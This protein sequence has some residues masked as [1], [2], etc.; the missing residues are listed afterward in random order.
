MQD[1]ELYATILG[2]HPPWRVERVDARSKEGEV[3]VFLE[4]DGSA[5]C[6]PT[7]QVASPRYDARRRSWRHLDTCQYRTVLTADVPRVSCKEHGIHQ[8]SVPWAEPGGRFTALFERLAIDWLTEA[9]ITAVARRLR[10]SWDELD[11][12]MHRAGT[13]LGRRAHQQLAQQLPRST[14]P[15]GDAR[16]ALPLVRLLRL[17]AHRA[18]GRETAERS[19]VLI[20]RS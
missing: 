5:L 2:I 1:R 12:I 14:D 10:V 9:S 7:C 19:Q 8:V 3:E 17:R 16:G 6:C 11:G 4:H 20:A 15:L 13:P 18:A